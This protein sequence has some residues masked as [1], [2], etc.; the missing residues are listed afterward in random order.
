[1]E[2]KPLLISLP[3]GKFISLDEAE[4][5]KELKIFTLDHIVK[6]DVLREMEKNLD[7]KLNQM[8]FYGYFFPLLQ[9]VDF[10]A[11]LCPLIP[12]TNYVAW[13]AP[14]K[15][16]EIAM[17]EF[18]SCLFV[19]SDK[20]T[21]PQL[22]NFSRNLLRLG[23]FPPAVGALIRLLK[24]RSHKFHHF[25]KALI[26]TEFSLL[27]QRMEITKRENIFESSIT[28]FSRILYLPKE[29]GVSLIDVSE[30]H[31]ICSKSFTSLKDALEVTDCSETRKFIERSQ[32]PNFK[33][34]TG[35]L[36]VKEPFDVNLFLRSTGLSTSM[37]MVKFDQ[38]LLQPEKCL[39]EQIMKPDLKHFMKNSVLRLFPPLS[40]KASSTPVLT[41]SLDLR[42]VVCSSKH[43]DKG[44]ADA[45]HSIR[46]LDLLNGKETGEDPHKLAKTLCDKGI[47]LGS[48]DER[49]CEEIISI[50][51]D[52]SSSM[53]N[54]AFASKEKKENP[55]QPKK[56]EDDLTLVKVVEK[57][58]KLPQFDNILNNLKKDSS[59]HNMSMT[60]EFFSYLAFDHPSFIPR[61]KYDEIL[62]TLIGNVKEEIEIDSYDSSFYCPIGLSLF[63]DPV[64]TADGQTYERTAIENWFRLGNKTSP[65]TGKELT[66]LELIPNIALRRLVETNVNK[67]FVPREKPLEMTH[68]N[69]QFV[70]NK[71]ATTQA[72]LNT[73]WNEITVDVHN[74]KDTLLNIRQKFAKNLK[75]LD[76]VKILRQTDMKFDEI[77]TNA[78]SVMTFYNSY[79]KNGLFNFEIN[80]CYRFDLVVDLNH[81]EL[82]QKISPVF[83]ENQI[84]KTE[85]KLKKFTFGD[86]DTVSFWVK[87]QTV[88][89]PLSMAAICFEVLKDKYSS[90]EDFLG[91]IM[92]ANGSWFSPKFTN[93]T[94]F[95]KK[96][97][98]MIY[99]KNLSGL[100]LDV[101]V[102]PDMLIGEVKN[103]I[104]KKLNDLQD[105]E[106]ILIFASLRLDDTKTIFSSSI[107]PESCLHLVLR[108]SARKN[109]VVEK[110]PV[111]TVFEDFFE[112]DD[113]KQIDEIILKIINKKGLNFIFNHRDC[114]VFDHQKNHVCK[115]LMKNLETVSVFSLKDGNVEVTKNIYLSV[116]Y[117][118]PVDVTIGFSKYI[119]H[120]NDTCFDVRFFNSDRNRYFSVLNTSVWSHLKSTGDGSRQGR[121]FNEND[122][123]Y[124]QVCY[125]S[126][127]NRDTFFEICQKNIKHFEAIWEGEGKKKE[128]T[129]SRLTVAKQCFETFL[130]KTAAFDYP[131][132]VALYTFS[133]DVKQAVSMT[134]LL[135]NFRK[136]MS[137][138]KAQGDTKMLDCVKKAAEDMIEY[139]QKHASQLSPGCKS[140]IIVLTDGEDNT[141]KIDRDDLID[142]LRTNDIVVDGIC[143]C[144]EE[145]RKLA[146]IVYATG[147]CAFHPQS[148]QD[149]LQII[150]LE[151]FL[152]LGERLYVVPENWEY[153][154]SHAKYSPFNGPNKPKRV[155]ELFTLP[156]TK[157]PLKNNAN[158]RGPKASV[159][160]LLNEFKSVMEQNHPNYQCF[161]IDN[162]LTK[163]RVI[164]VAP[165]SSNKMEEDSPYKG[166]VFVVNVKF[167]EDY[168]ESPPEVRFETPILHIN[169]NPYGKVCHD[170]LGRGYDRDQSMTHIL[171][172]VYGLLLVQEVNSPFDSNLAT[173][174]HENYNLYLSKIREHVKQYASKSLRIVTNL[175]QQGKPIY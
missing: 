42:V 98:F 58:K 11:L 148:S 38:K 175:V 77:L 134:G 126:K 49:P 18:L 127:E 150:E 83:D 79:S 129:L 28:L 15:Q 107:G 30:V 108:D 155:G 120:Y 14:V 8:T 140:R 85:Y 47:D 156:V 124:T 91:Q 161:V 159:M 117:Y 113:E 139:R 76:I 7:I 36:S 22:L 123:L 167:P 95:S 172:S 101:E 80:N 168:P 26:A 138:V 157:E 87:K 19:L 109:Q 116:V 169:C 52:C 31:L 145:S 4:K 158:L 66:S 133:S 23:M 143:V 151:V 2:T 73:S 44:E 100:T 29:D 72:F 130:D 56:W 46:L 131:H 128:R 68:V 99:V 65:L 78:K 153:R 166:G 96:K 61:D 10:D 55:Y 92:P 21:H 111:V 110:V 37:T 50:L 121:V 35:D 62:R 17:S 1:M 75:F 152:K 170:I 141:S 39:T 144:P 67:N 13:Q 25:E 6:L 34:D 12:F 154:L 5:E 103:L 115:S 43:G 84:K 9:D 60:M 69:V 32:L 97:P 89:N 24:N 135:D 70:E 147:G 27:F 142:F 132:R 164:M 82:L 86:H 102:T 112:S 171:N 93:F 163:W 74:T 71:E 122:Y 118:P 125:F 94:K 54:E 136:S 173:L 20:L 160:R 146:N 106:I 162:D 64:M 41:K 40:L 137:G 16:S 174:F 33:K 63:K 104:Y 90:F 53:N 51:L 59:A 57:I 105:K 81:T 45:A 119:I 165:K 88:C 149:Q 3:D 114:R 48:F